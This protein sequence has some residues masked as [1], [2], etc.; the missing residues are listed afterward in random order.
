LEIKQSFIA[1]TLPLRLSARKIF[2]HHKKGYIQLL[3]QRLRFIRHREN[4]RV[5][6]VDGITI[7]DML[8]ELARR[9]GARDFDVH[10]ATT[11]D[12]AFPPEQK[13]TLFQ[14]LND[15]EEKYSWRADI[16]KIMDRHWTMKQRRK[17]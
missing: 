9:A 1:E 3:K 8:N 12:H 7:E 10:Y 5:T 14:L 17:R 15:I 2:C 11:I 13:L 6:G 16:T 4:L